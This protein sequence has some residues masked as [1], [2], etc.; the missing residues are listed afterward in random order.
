MTV[1]KPRWNRLYPRK[2][3]GQFKN[4][5]RQCWHLGITSFGGPTVHFQQFY[6]RFVTKAQWIDEEIYQEL[7]SVTQAC[8][9]PASTKML[10]CINLMHDGFLS[11]CLGFLLWSLPG[12]VIMYG[13]S[14][15]VSSIGDGLP[16]PVYAL[17]SGLN[18]ATVGIIALAGVQLSEK[19]ITDTPTRLLVFFG[20]AAGLLYNALWYFP[21]VMVVAGIV[22]VVYDF[23]WLHTPV[24]AIVR[25]INAP[26]RYAKRMAKR[27]NENGPQN[28]PENTAQTTD[29]DDLGPPTSTVAGASSS[30]DP[31]PT[32]SNRDTN[33]KEPSL[34]TTEHEA[35]ELLSTDS[36]PRIVPAERRLNF[37]WKFG[38]SII[39][40]FF[41]SFA[42]IM[43]IRGVVKEKP[44]LYDVFANFFLAGTIIFGG[45]PVVIPLLREY[46][47]TEGWVRPRDFLI[48]V[49]II[50][51]M[52]GPNFN[53][54]VYLGS[55]AAITLGYPPISG[56]IIGYIGLFTPGL[57]IVHGTMGVWG[58]IRGLRAVK[59][60]IRGVNAA[61]VGLMYTAVYR[62]WQIGYI[63][64]GFQQGSSLANEPWWV[65]VTASSYV[66]GYWFGMNP[67]TA[68][69]VGAVMGMI[70]YGV[71]SA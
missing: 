57:V 47:V 30:V 59:S 48:G 16:R 18:S 1:R 3:V 58:S 6:I 55:L 41:L 24:K 65:V 28:T 14:I 39:V 54:A 46:V 25:F 56:A 9:G 49:A 20:A 35:H 44:A 69:V 29:L 42:V 51:S 40:G 61:A 37:T 71:S 15:G 23:R 53:V 19:T 8:S 32:S 31:G 66:G 33:R 45:G 60:A 34:P 7:F 17:L 26:L 4:T 63:D 13:L 22:T 68:I 27:G 2:L 70:Y 5:L 43:T 12:A 36:E 10:Y 64:E 21:V 67:P 38:L 62:L 50:Q 11:A 52:P